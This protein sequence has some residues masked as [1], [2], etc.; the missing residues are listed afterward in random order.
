[1]PLKKIDGVIEA[2]RYLPDGRIAAVRAYEARGAVWSD[3]VL[4][5]RTELVDRLKKGMKFVT[6]QRK[7]YFGS[8]LEAEVP[9]RYE[10]EFITT[11]NPVDKRDLLTGVPIF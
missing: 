11:D 9:I 7:V 4:L 8:T 2:V 3:H 1:M 10:S 6:G 5:D